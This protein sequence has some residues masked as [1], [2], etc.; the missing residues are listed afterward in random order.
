[1]RSGISKA[2]GGGG[3]HDGELLLEPRWLHEL[4]GQGFLGDVILHLGII[5][6]SQDLV[7]FLRDNILLLESG[8]D[9]I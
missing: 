7:S 4:L 6:G 1:M 5:I 9:E 8:F 2:C 3:R